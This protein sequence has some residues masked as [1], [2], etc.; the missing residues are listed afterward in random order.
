MFSQCVSWNLICTASTS[1]CR[2]S[3][4]DEV[5]YVAFKSGTSRLP[6]REQNAL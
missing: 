1:M 6:L 3:S 5:D 4:I 2:A